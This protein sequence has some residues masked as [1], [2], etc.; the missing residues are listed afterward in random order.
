MTPSGKIQKFVLLEQIAAGD[1]VAVVAAP[2]E[3]IARIS[4]SH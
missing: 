1:L 3:S 2:S 4:V